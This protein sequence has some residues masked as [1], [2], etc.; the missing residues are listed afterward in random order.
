[1]WWFVPGANVIFQWESRI[2]GWE[3]DSY[4]L[5][6]SSPSGEV[7]GH[8]TLFIFLLVGTLGGVYIIEQ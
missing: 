3:A 7:D 6:F 1:M 5:F 8:D 2:D 4:C